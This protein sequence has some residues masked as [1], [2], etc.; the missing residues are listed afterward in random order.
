MTN[1]SEVKLRISPIKNEVFLINCKNN[2]ISL[3]QELKTIL[4]CKPSIKG[5]KKMG[6]YYLKNE[7]LCFLL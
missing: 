7:F 4:K 3:E 1:V 6:I 2:M 5:I